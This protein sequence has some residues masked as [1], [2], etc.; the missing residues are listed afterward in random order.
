MK[1]LESQPRGNHT[2]PIQK[3]DIMCKVNELK[4]REQ[5]RASDG[6][7]FFVEAEYIHHWIGRI[8]C[9]LK[10]T[11]KMWAKESQNG[12]AVWE[13]VREV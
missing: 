9:N 6:M 8:G 1:E 7:F 11:K 5:V 3:Q 12:D 4:S 2:T 13:K 10:T